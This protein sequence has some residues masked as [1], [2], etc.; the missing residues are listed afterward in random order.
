MDRF[1][2]RYI[3]R[4]IDGSMDR[5]FNGSMDQLIGGSIEG[6]ESKRECLYEIESEDFVIISGR[7]T[8]FEIS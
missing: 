8:P 1:I 2:D 7:S 6:R 3:D 5:W 4:W